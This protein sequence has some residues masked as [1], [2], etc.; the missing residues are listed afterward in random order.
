MI[1][2]I[3]A[4]DMLRLVGRFAATFIPTC[5]VAAVGLWLASSQR[6]I[7]VALG[8]GVAIAFGFFGLMQL[9]VLVRGLSYAVKASARLEELEQRDYELF[10][11]GKSFEEINSQYKKSH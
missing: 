11:Q 5:G 4:E 9:S 7:V 2:P 1:S 10:K 6:G 3:K 8:W